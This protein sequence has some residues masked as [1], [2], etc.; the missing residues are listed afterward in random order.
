[1]SALVG[2][3]DTD[4]TSVLNYSLTETLA[5]LQNYSC[6]LH[7]PKLILW[8]WGEKAA[9]P[10]YKETQGKITYG[11][12]GVPLCIFE[13]L[14]SYEMFSVAHIG[15]CRFL[16]CW[17]F[18]TGWFYTV[19]FC[20]SAPNKCK[21]YSDGHLILV[22]VQSLSSSFKEGYIFKKWSAVL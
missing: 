6:F 21:V 8:K 9:F 7:S 14:C 5:R 18:H 4:W 12:V 22:G 3:S 17:V 10:R 13:C 15:Y 2:H 16:R 19:S 11:C 20:P 1:M